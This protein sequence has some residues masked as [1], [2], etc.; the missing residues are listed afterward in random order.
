ME[1]L[2]GVTVLQKNDKERNGYYFEF[3]QNIKINHR[4]DKQK[5]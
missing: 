2:D 1:I 4:S 3:K 5:C